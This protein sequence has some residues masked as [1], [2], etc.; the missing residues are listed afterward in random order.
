[1]ID[2]QAD[3]VE[4]YGV[5]KLGTTDF[6]VVQQSYTSL[7]SQPKVEERSKLNGK[8]IFLI[9][10]ILGRSQ[11]TPQIKVKYEEKKIILSNLESHF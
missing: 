10:K 6:Q 4:K 11:W 1:M 8:N 9:Y 2:L 5:Q 7:R 3:F